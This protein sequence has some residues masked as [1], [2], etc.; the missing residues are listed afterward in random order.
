[1]VILG[2]DGVDC[3]ELFEESLE[4]GEV[5]GVSPV[6]L[7]LRRVVVDLQEDSIDASGYGGSGENG[8]ELGLAA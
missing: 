3:K 8:D 6:R 7:S 5:E 1:M 4:V 2:D